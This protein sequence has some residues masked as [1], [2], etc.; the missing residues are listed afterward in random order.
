[1]KKMY[2]EPISEI[3]RLEANVVMQDW[4]PDSF[5]HA[6]GGQGIPARKDQVPVF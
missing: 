5:S 3:I 6:P 1:M 2:I 4:L